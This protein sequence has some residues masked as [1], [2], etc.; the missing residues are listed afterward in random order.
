LWESLKGEEESGDGSGRGGRKLTMA[1]EMVEEWK[2]MIV[3]LCVSSAMGI[4][5]VSVQI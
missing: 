1:A 5:T 4:A 3:A 2:E